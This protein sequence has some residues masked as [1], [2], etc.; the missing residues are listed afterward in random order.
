MLSEEVD[1]L[2]LYRNTAPVAKSLRFSQQ[3]GYSRFQSHNHS[4]SNGKNR[5]QGHLL[6]LYYIPAEVVTWLVVKGLGCHPSAVLITS[7]HY[8]EIHMDDNSIARLKKEIPSGR[9]L[10]HRR[11]FHI[12]D[13][14]IEIAVIIDAF[15]NMQVV[16]PR[17][18]CPGQTCGRRC[19]S[20]H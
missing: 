11:Y 6:P 16:I 14:T 1:N 9:S 13:D 17:C 19:C 5:N 8:L 12:I 4:T 2:F 7:V 10:S 20:I 15:S 3:S 18:K